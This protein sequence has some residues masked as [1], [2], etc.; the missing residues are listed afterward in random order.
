MSAGFTAR[1]GDGRRWRPGALWP[2]LALVGALANTVASI[3]DKVA[4][5]PDMEWTAVSAPVPVAEG[6]G[7]S[8]FC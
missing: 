2:A 3:Y 4:G 7:R 8:Q 6:N 5:K 1:G